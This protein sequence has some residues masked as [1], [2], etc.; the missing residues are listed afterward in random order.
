MNGPVA[1]T[2]TRANVIQ[3]MTQPAPVNSLRIT[4]RM[5]TEAM[6]EPITRD[7]PSRTLISAQESIR[8]MRRR[9]HAARHVGVRIRLPTGPV[10]APIDLPEAG[11]LSYNKQITEDR[12]IDRIMI[13]RPGGRSFR[14]ARDLPSSRFHPS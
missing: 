8:S 2:A 4:R 12:S 1:V 9:L 14:Q 3:T 11:H 6:A 10:P 13:V 5:W 7:T